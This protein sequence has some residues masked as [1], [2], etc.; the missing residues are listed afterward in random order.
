MLANR[1]FR[2]SVVSFAIA[3]LCALPLAAQLEDKSTTDAGHWSIAPR[4]HG[5]ARIVPGGME[6][7]PTTRD[8]FFITGNIQ[9]LGYDR[10]ELKKI[11]VHFRIASTY[12]SLNSI[13]VTDPRFGEILHVSTGAHGDH[14][15]P[16][17]DVYTPTTSAN[18]WQLPVRVPPVTVD[19]KTVVRLGM[20]LGLPIDSGGAGEP[21]VLYGVDIYCAKKVLQLPPPSQTNAPRTGGVVLVPGAPPPKP[22]PP[23]PVANL[24][25][26]R[27]VI[28]AISPTNELLWYRHTGRED[29][30]F[31][32]AAEAKTVGH[33]WAFRTV[34]GAGNGVIYAITPE[35]DLVWY[36]HEGRGDGSFN[37]IQS[38]GKTVNTGFRGMQVISAGGG[39][40][41]ALRRTGEL[42]WYRHDGYADGSDRWTAKEGRLVSSNFH[43]LRIFAGDRGIIYALTNSG[44]L[45]RFR[46]EGRTDGT[47]RWSDPNGMKIASNWNYFQAF[48]S[49]DG[50]L[51]GLTSDKRLMWFRDNGRDNDTI[52]WTS[53]NGNQVGVG[54]DVKTIFSGAALE[55]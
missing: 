2:L 35:G 40:I 1:T 51:Y 9:V 26:S 38:E 28:Y 44:D 17:F 15:N 54:W 42:L 55:P 4:S 29:G 8:P 20:N 41:Y 21:F 18:A 49:G 12:S 33:G 16:R 36:R 25:D 32:W 10:C 37:W 23:A 47:N 22:A 14:S 52:N 53:E 43:F 11:V 45:Y 31:K 27:A 7:R 50:I 6:F 46:H 48:S 13:E 5:Q 24:P 19:S 34:I 30:S 39:V 3:A